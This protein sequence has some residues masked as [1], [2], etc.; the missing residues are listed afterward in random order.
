[1]ADGSDED[2]SQKTEEPTPKKLQDAR[3]R[4]QVATSR[5]VNNFVMIFAGAIVLLIFGPQVSAD[6]IHLFKNLI[7]NSYQF[8]TSP[9]GILGVL[10]QVLY[11]V[12]MILFLPIFVLF[13]AAIIGPFAQ[14][15]PI[16]SAESMKPSLDKISPLKGFKRLFS[17]RSFAEFFKGLLKIAILTAVGWML[18]VPF[19][20]T[21]D[22]F[23]GQPV[24]YAMRDMH[25]MA[26][27]LFIGFLSIIA[28]IAIAD[29]MYQRHEHMK[30]LRMSKQEIKDEYK[31]LEGDPHI[32]SRL[33]QLRAD[34]ARAR[35]MAAVPEADVVITNPT[36]YALALK[37]DSE[38]MNAPVLIAKGI[39]KVALRIRD[40]AEEHDITIVEN[41]PLARAL[42]DTMDL[43]EMIPEEH[44]KAVA[45]VISYVFRLKGKPM[46]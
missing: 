22:H 23:I 13:I 9:Y 35:M 29:Y 34:K 45:E 43:D 6:L 7:T 28:V 39:D 10:K 33:R 25:A 2:E 15:G 36:H 3:K 5:E 17:M 44:Y 38:N 32:K 4:G 42:Y 21:I 18:M 37:Y 30:K 14:I 8:P 20:E 27:R 24:I 46:R 12:A 1:M 31:Q 16:F 40:L 19:Y 41:P 11:E 26:T